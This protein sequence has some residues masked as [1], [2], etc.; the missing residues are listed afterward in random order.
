M[1][2]RYLQFRSLCT[3]SDFC[4]VQNK[5][6][7]Q[8]QACLQSWTTVEENW[9][10]MTSE[11]S[12]F[13]FANIGDSI[14]CTSSISCSH[15]HSVREKAFTRS[16]EKCWVEPFLLW[17]YGYCAVKMVFETSATIVGNRRSWIKAICSCHF[18]CV[19]W[20]H[21]QHC[22]SVWWV[23]IVILTTPSNC[24]TCCMYVYCIYFIWSQRNWRN[25]C[26]WSS[27]LIPT[28]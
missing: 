16:E 15:I 4:P 21:C 17:I 6:L 25:W 10:V 3:L 5:K 28:Y 8:V 26:C 18:G 22:N 11:Q 23:R 9:F 13:I 27:V 20:H 19:L 24:L 7:W 14:I 1:H 12:D 2:G